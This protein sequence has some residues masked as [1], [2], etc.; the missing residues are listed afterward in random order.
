MSEMQSISPLMASKQALD[1]LHV[2]M[3]KCLSDTSKFNSIEFRMTL[4][5]QRRTDVDVRFDYSCEKLAPAELKQ[6]LNFVEAQEHQN[7]HVSFRYGAGYL[8]GG[9]SFSTSLIA[10]L[11]LSEEEFFSPVLGKALFKKLEEFE[12]GLRDN[13]EGVYLH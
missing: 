7:I 11:A 3:A 5:E 6:R 1:D 9:K 10:C 4:P 13:N 8:P 2:H 12:L